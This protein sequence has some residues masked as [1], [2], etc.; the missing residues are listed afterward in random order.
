METSTPFKQR[1]SCSLIDQ[2]VQETFFHAVPLNEQAPKQND[3]D[4]KKKEVVNELSARL[5]QSSRRQSRD[6]TTISGRLIMKPL[7]D[8]TNEEAV[9]NKTPVAQ[10]AMNKQRN[11]S[12]GDIQRQLRD[13]FTYTQTKLTGQRKNSMYNLV[14]VGK[15]VH[16]NWAYQFMGT[17]R[18]SVAT[19]DDPTKQ[20]MTQSRTF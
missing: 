10:Y 11:H 2:E 5:I 7:L 4:V 19:L 13:Q 8:T 1:L 9:V 18:R 3:L 17:P 16:K 12:V 20:S 14:D 15:D 6:N